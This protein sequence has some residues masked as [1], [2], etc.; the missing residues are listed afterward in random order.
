[1]WSHTRFGR[2]SVTNI[3]NYFL[4]A[5]CHDGMLTCLTVP[6]MPTL[7]TGPM[8]SFLSHRRNCQ[9]RLLLFLFG[10]MSA[11][12]II[13]A[14]LFFRWAMTPFWMP[15]RDCQ[16]R[17]IFQACV[18]STYTWQPKLSWHFKTLLDHRLNN[19]NASISA[20][21]F[22]DHVHL[23]YRLDTWCQIRFWHF[24]NLLN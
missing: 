8:S 10:S 9:H 6:L 7:F 18:R 22:L 24:R 3:S 23:T 14:P 11:R 4:C 17:S 13:L 19:N 5:C 12:L 1:M 20:I 15:R 21:Q 2:L 16:H